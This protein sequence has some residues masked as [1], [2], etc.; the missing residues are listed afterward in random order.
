[1]Y[2]FNLAST[3]YATANPLIYC[4]EINPYA[5]PVRRL[6]AVE[7]FLV[8]VVMMGKS[9]SVTVAERRSISLERV[10]GSL[11]CEAQKNLEAAFSIPREERIGLNRGHC[12]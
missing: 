2:V 1:M 12:R 11:G 7:S 5:T 8:C 4:Y 3:L 6:W 10:P 9:S